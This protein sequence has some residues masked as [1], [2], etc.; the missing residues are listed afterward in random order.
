MSDGL[1]IIILAVLNKL[2]LKV[3][4]FYRYLIIPFKSDVI[5]LL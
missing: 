2:L 4:N 1:V 3:N 5:K